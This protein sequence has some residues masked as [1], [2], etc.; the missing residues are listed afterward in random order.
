MPMP[1]PDLITTREASDL[2][3]VVVS[4]VTRMVERGDLTPVQKLASGQLLFDRETVQ[5]LAEKRKR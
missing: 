4:T 2:L 3:G 5:A 1:M